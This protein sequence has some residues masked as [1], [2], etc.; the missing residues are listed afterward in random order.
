GYPIAVVA[1]CV[2]QTSERERFGDGRVLRAAFRGSRLIQHRP[3]HALRSR[4]FDEHHVEIGGAPPCFPGVVIFGRVVERLGSFGRRKLN[5]DKT[6]RVE[7]SLQYRSRATAH[8][9][10]AA[11][12]RNGRPR[13]LGVILELF[14]LG[15]S[16]DGHEIGWHGVS[17]LRTGES[18]WHQDGDLRC[19]RRQTASAL[20]SFLTIRCCN[21]A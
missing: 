13:E 6:V 15:H 9:E 18:R 2:A 11:I 7:L 21:L 19:A 16:Y 4:T 10:L 17:P 1:Q 14:L 5:Y 8:E 12:L 20:R 3:P